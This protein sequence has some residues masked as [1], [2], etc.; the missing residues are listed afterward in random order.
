MK[1]KLNLFELLWRSCKI[2]KPQPFPWSTLSKSVF[3]KQPVLYFPF[4]QLSSTNLNQQNHRLMKNSSWSS[5]CVGHLRVS[6]SCHSI[7]PY[8]S[9]T[10]SEPW[11]PLLLSH[12]LRYKC[13]PS[14]SNF[15]WFHQRYNSHGGETQQK[16][17]GRSSGTT[18]VPQVTSTSVEREREFVL[19]TAGRELLNWTFPYIMDEGKKKKHML[20]EEVQTKAVNLSQMLRTE[21]LVRFVPGTSSWKWKMWGQTCVMIFS[22]HAKT[23]FNRKIE[24]CGRANV[25]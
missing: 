4:F 25:N 2:Q 7:H 3:A 8:S 22:K 13:W 14:S 6:L 19:Q 9:S 15:L 17:N 5:S 1:L 10:T 18:K 24:K 12:Q 11:R 21:Y 16:K 23:T 20:K